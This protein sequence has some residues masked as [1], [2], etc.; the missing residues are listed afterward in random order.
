MF[1]VYGVIVQGEDF[2]PGLGESDLVYAWA[3]TM[4]A[5]GQIVIVLFY[6]LIASNFPYTLS[7]ILGCL[8]AISGGILHATAVKGWMVIVSQFLLGCGSGTIALVHTYIGEEGTMMDKWRI[9]HNKKPLKFVLHIWLSFTMNG[10][11][12]LGYGMH[13]YVHT[14][15]VL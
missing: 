11:V 15:R 7:F 10:G 2:W 5:V 9:K 1:G 14:Y 3:F 6:G 13:M 8:L 12:L 4:S